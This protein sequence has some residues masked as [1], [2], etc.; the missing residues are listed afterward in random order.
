MF[1]KLFSNHIDLT[2]DVYFCSRLTY[3]Y[4][5][6]IKSC[7]YE[8]RYRVNTL[9]VTGMGN[10]IK[11]EKV[12]TCALRNMSFVSRGK[13]KSFVVLFLL[14]RK[15]HIIEIPLNSPANRWQ[16]EAV[17]IQYATTFNSS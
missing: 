2:V 9:H 5:A 17:V 6:C 4:F 14:M 3:T 15:I 13:F 1:L 7:P 12:C 16:Y 10:R 8:K 11:M